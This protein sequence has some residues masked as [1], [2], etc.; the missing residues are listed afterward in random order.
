MVKESEIIRRQFKWAAIFL[1]PSLII[2]TCSFVTFLLLSEYSSNPEDFC[3]MLSGVTAA[4]SFAV[5]VSSFYFRIVV[6][7]R[8]K[9]YKKPPLAEEDIHHGNFLIIIKRLIILTF[10]NKKS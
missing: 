1:L 9:Y 7:E 4:F 8:Y 3:V 6:W 10:K 2:F 5:M